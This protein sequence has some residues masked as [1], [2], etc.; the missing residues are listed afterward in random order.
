M[1]LKRAEQRRAQNDL[2]HLPPGRDLAQGE[3]I[4]GYSQDRHGMAAAA[5]LAHDS[6][7][8]AGDCRPH[9]ACGEPQ[10]TGEGSKRSGQRAKSRAASTAATAAGS[11]RLAATEESALTL[12]GGAEGE[13]KG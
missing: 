10:A 3:E 12:I 5:A 2:R 6:R 9:R 1:L 4:G 11:S 8:I 7:H 13:G